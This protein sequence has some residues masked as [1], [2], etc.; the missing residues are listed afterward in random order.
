MQSVDYELRDRTEH[1][2]QAWQ[3]AGVGRIS[4]ILVIFSSLRT[5]LGTW[6]HYFELSSRLLLQSNAKPLANEGL[7]RT[8][9]KSYLGLRVQQ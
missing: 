5:Y 1:E 7:G 6:I 4:S 2:A 9:G 3:K 8:S